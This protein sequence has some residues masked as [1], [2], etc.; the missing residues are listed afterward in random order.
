M[1]WGDSILRDWGQY[2]KK[3][4]E[5]KVRDAIYAILKMRC[6]KLLEENTHSKQNNT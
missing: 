2:H 4:K 6:T 5:A 3:K 1:Y